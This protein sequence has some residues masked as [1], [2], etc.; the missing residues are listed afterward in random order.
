MKTLIFSLTQLSKAVIIA[1]LSFFVINLSA[2]EKPQSFDLQEFI[3]IEINAR[4][5]PIIIPPGVYKLK[6]INKGHLYFK[7][8]RN[9]TLIADNVKIVC[10]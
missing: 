5:N 8:L 3:D 7:N 1:F 2:I 10:S 9:L 4:K 6:P